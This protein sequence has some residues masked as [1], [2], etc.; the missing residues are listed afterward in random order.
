[1]TVNWQS[2]GTV[3]HREDCLECRVPLDCLRHCEVVQ[4]VHEHDTPSSNEGTRGLVVDKLLVVFINIGNSV[5]VC[6]LHPVER[7]V[8]PQDSTQIKPSGDRTNAILRS[9]N[10]LVSCRRYCKDK[11]THIYV[12]VCRAPARWSNTEDESESLDLG[13]A[14]I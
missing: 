3:P 4:L 5:T 10:R 13:Q 12:S 8:T 11:N 2:G 14:H 6:P 9:E 7:V 1:M